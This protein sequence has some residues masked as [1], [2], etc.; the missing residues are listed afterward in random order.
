MTI[1]S[2][3]FFLGNAVVAGPPYFCAM[4]LIAEGEIPDFN[5]SLYMFVISSVIL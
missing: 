1:V 2:D 5:V 3:P 4:G